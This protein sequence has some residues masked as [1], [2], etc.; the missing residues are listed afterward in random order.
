MEV[1]IPDKKLK[2]AL[3]DDR[4]CNRRY[5]TQMA[6]KIRLRMEALR[7]AESLFDFWPPLEGPERC[8]ELKADRKGT[9]SMDVKQPYRLLFRPT[10]ELKQASFP[11]EKDR[12]RAI[13]AVTILGIEDTH[14]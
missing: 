4:E 7:A 2:R 13:K 3:E 1:E 9:F 12:W 5:G 11:D 10:D 8:H 14:E 6:K